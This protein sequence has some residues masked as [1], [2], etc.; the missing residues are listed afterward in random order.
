MRFLLLA[1]LGLPLPALAGTCAIKVHETETGARTEPGKS[2]EHLFRVGRWPV[3]F[4]GL[5]TRQDDG[6]WRWQLRLE[7]RKD[8]AWDV[9]VEQDLRTGPGLDVVVET[10][11]RLGPVTLRCRD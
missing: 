4:V 2:S 3:R 9:I 11:S 1:L 6:A 7:R 8:D 5:Q 10:D